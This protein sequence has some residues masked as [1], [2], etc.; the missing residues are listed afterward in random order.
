MYSARE[1]NRIFLTLAVIAFISVIF[2][3]AVFCAAGYRADFKPNLIEIGEKLRLREYRWENEEI[4]PGHM[5]LGLAYRSSFLGSVPDLRE[6]YREFDAR[7]GLVY[8]FK[9]PGQYPFFR[10]ESREGEFFTFSGRDMRIPGM[11]IDIQTIGDRMEKIRKSSLREV[12]VESVRY[13]L[14]RERKETHRKGLLDIDIPIDLPDQLEWFIG[15]GEET[16]LSITGREEISIGGTSQWCSNCPRTEGRPEPQKFPDLDMKQNLAVDL[17]GTI[18]EKIKVK[19][20]HSSQG[21]G[22]QSVN[23]VNVRYQG[24]DDDII[25]LIEMGDTDLS[26]KGATLVRYSGSAQG[27]FGI[28][29]KAQLG[30]VDMT[31][32]A[33]KEEGETATGTFKSSGGQ[34]SRN[35]IEDYRFMKRQFFYFENPGESFLSPQP[36][37]FRYPVGE[38]QYL[39][40]VF[41][42]LDES[43]LQEI[44]D[45][46]ARWNVKAYPAPLNGAIDP[47]SNQAYR[48]KF[49]QLER[50]EDFE[51]IR[52]Y[53]YEGDEPRY[54]GIYLYR[55]LP[56]EKALVVRYRNNVGDVIGDYGVYPESESD[57]LTAELICPRDEDFLP[58]DEPGAKYPTT[59]YMMMR[60]VYSLGLGDIRGG[61]L[62][63][64]IEET[65][66]VTGTKSMEDSTGLSYLRIFG[67]DRVDDAGN[68]EPDDRIDNTEGLINYHHG[69]LMFPWP[70]PFKI[71]E[72][73]MRDYLGDTATTVDAV[74]TRNDLIYDGKP[75]QSQMPHKF[76]IVVEGSSGQKTLQLNAFNIIE[77]SEVVRVGGKTLSRGTDY[78]IDYLSGIVTLKGDI[79]LEIQNDPNA[80]INIDYQKEPLIGGQKSSLL[81][82]AA[83]YEIS[84]N[85]RINGMF[86]YN[87]TGASKYRPKLGAEPTRNMAGDINSDFIF[88]PSW[89]TS[90]A[91]LL[92]RVDTSEESRVNFGGELALSIP[93]PNTKGS[94]FVEDMEGVE[95]SDR[96]RMT[97]QQWYQ[98]SPPLDPADDGRTLNPLPEGM[99]FYWYNP[100]TTD[101]QEDLVTSKEDLNP[102]IDERENARITSL[103]MKAINPEDQQ[104]MG[105]MSGFVGGLDLTTAQYLEIWVNDYTPDS[106]SRAG[107]VHIDFGDIDEDFFNPELNQYDDEKNHP[108]DDKIWIATE[109]DKG[110]PAGEE[111]PTRRYPERFDESTYDPDRGI[112]KWINS[113]IGN[114]I[115]DTEDMNGNNRLDEDNYYYSMEF[116][117]ADSAL[118]DVRRDFPGYDIEGNKSWRLY[119]LDLD[120]LRVMGNYPPRLD[121]ISHM[122]IWVEDAEQI[123]ARVG[124]SGT[125]H[126]L[127]LAE[128]KFVGSKWIYNNIRDLEGN[129]RSFAEIQADDM[130]VKVGTLNNKDNPSIYKSPFDVEEEEGIARKEQSLVFDVENF[131]DSTGFKYFRNYVGEGKNFQQYRE[132]EFYYNFDEEL[133]SR[134]DEQSDEA[135]FFLQI[136]HDSLKYYEIAIPITGDMDPGWRHVV[137]ELSEL[138]NLKI[139]AESERVEGTIRDARY[140]GRTYRGRL[141]G[142]P[143]LSRVRY[144]FAGLRN[145]SDNIIP[146]TRFMFNDIILSGVRRDTD[147]AAKA[148]IAV[149]LGG[150]VL[151]LRGS[152][153]RTGAEFR[154]LQQNRGSGMTRNNYGVGGKTRLGHFIP[155]AGFN[156]PVSLDFSYSRSKP[157]YLTQ[158]DVEIQEE[159]VRDSL[160]AASRSYKFGVSLTRSGSSNFL[161]KNLFDNLSLNYSYSR[162]GSYSPTSKDTIIS[163]GGSLNYN[164]T[165]SRDRVIE[166]FKGI[167]WH[168]W[169]SNLSFTANANRNV[170]KSYYIRGDDFIKAPVNYSAGWTNKMHFAYDPF[171]SMKMRYDRQETRDMGMKHQFH[172]ITIGMLKN[173]NESASFVFDPKSGIPLISQFS[174]YFRYQVSYSENLGGKRRAEDPMGTRGV[175]MGRTISANLDFKVGDYAEDILGFVEKFGPERK[176][177][178]E[179]EKKRR[180][181]SRTVNLNFKVFIDRKYNRE[182]LSERERR[183][184]TGEEDE[185]P[186]LEKKQGKYLKLISRYLREEKKTDREEMVEPEEAEADSV[187]AGGVDR[188]WI[189]KKFFG[190]LSRIHPVKTGL[191][192]RNNSSYDYLYDRASLGYRLGFQEESGA[193]GRSGKKQKVPVVAGQTLELNMSTKL[194]LTEDIK[195]N[196]GG[197]YTRTIRKSNGGEDESENIIWPDMSLSWAG[198]GTVGF[199]GNYIK[200]SSF[201]LNYERRQSIR[202]FNTRTENRVSPDWTQ[203]WVNGLISTLSLTYKQEDKDLRG[204]LMWE[205]L[206]QANLNLRYDISGKKG[207]GLPIPFLGD[208]KI[209][210]KSNLT[211]SLSISYARNDYHDRPPSSSIAVT[212]QFTYG[213]SKNIRGNLLLKYARRSGGIRGLINQEIQVSAS[214]TFKF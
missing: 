171:E 187:D 18:G 153:Q 4:P 29:T 41:I 46:V 155:T 90:L 11:D 135:E 191:D 101:Q 71:P 42:E 68:P 139:D 70:E 20:S 198:L 38:G 22:M 120:S 116:S 205:K 145:R 88:K 190:A 143:L 146:A 39:V 170:K 172:G 206:Y 48:A 201:N 125:E 65:D 67:L 5:K 117:L 98:A 43:D 17:N 52:D 213:F 134:F 194:D 147:Y 21:T 112:Y 76:D 192:L 144:L 157:K 199:L 7:S 33:S 142:T 189:V 53:G 24:F 185:L 2:S 202:Q 113:R 180:I 1:L 26:L 27:L 15:E 161:M 178:K 200:T 195:I 34:T 183:L 141:R 118:I 103:F 107:T 55:P 63:I 79:L 188:L 212:P 154:S 214:A 51:L 133:I 140:A 122:R 193:V 164:L 203:T 10:R 108:P 197:R 80:E 45:D 177:E 89:L 56:E 124:S 87:S 12:W 23:K 104:W 81:G 75:S 132:I 3:S 30:P 40:E 62:D 106:T 74:L 167:K 83:E 136:A 100:A 97:R 127:E 25:K 204:Q 37:F 148:N 61:T 35:V 181:R 175:N 138:T 105:V 111:Y 66:K 130:S 121:A 16:N 92:P 72:P 186:P 85:A 13:E 151:S 131:A 179:T 173:Y 8:E 78:D 50:Y 207:I 49:T 110:F 114:N 165:F 36:G 137:I 58:P 96:L 77:G 95:D 28:K 86:L 32:V 196:L 93:D 160:V 99:E 166:L 128:L 174:P 210:F 150:G 94:A 47:S 84:Q 209:S 57:T 156:I 123:N 159:S 115:H 152:W 149:N 102:K 184:L 158:S 60:N 182:K 14:E 31:F 6:S 9:I 211:S 126:L 44:T 109:D 163:M 162:Q 119:R 64:S 208:K 54:I 169:L 176:E 69:W 129:I 73:V 19:I 168:Y 91:N 59:W 82:L